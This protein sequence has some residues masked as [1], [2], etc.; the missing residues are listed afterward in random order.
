ME[1]IVKYTAVGPYYS[2][3]TLTYI[4]SNA[5]EIDNIQF[6][7]EKHMAREH[8]SLSMIYKLE[9]IFDNSEI[10]CRDF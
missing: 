9:I 4:G 5:E 3:Q 10:F 8:C 2:D 6:E 1:R 7:T